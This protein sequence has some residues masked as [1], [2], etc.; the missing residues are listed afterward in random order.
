MASCHYRPGNI[1]AFETWGEREGGEF[2][3]E[4]PNK[5]QV[6][7]EISHASVSIWASKSTKATT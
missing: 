3:N 5:P 7:K 2:Y 6:V 4:V 1:G